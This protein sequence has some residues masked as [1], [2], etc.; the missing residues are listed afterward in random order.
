MN[1]SKRTRIY[2]EDITIDSLEVHNFWAKRSDKNLPYAYNLVNFQ[3]SHPEVAIERDRIEKNKISKFLN[4]KEDSMILD[5]GC[6]IGRWF[7]DIGNK[8]TSGKY[9][10]VDYTENFIKLAGDKFKNCRNCH[11]IQGNFNSLINVLKANGEY[12]SYN[13]IFVNGILMY[14]ND[15]DLG[16]CLSFLNELL[17]PN[18]IIYIKESVGLRQRLTLQNYYSEEL[19]A[20]YSVIYRT[21]DQYFKYIHEYLKG[22]CVYAC[23]PTFIDYIDYDSETSNWFWIIKKVIRDK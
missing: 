6:G 8:I 21:V 11:F 9:V 17:V 20:Q 12:R 5:V 19:Q 23:G 4:I 2:G 10:G 3:D 16:T 13:N 1:S 14:I 7:D 18:G 22:M 15:E